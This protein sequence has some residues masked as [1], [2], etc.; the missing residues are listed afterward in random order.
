VLVWTQKLEEKSVAF[1]GD[2]TSIAQS[3]ARQL[4]WLSYHGSDVNMY[5]FHIVIEP[6]YRLYMCE[7]LYQEHSLLNIVLS[8][9]LRELF[10]LELIFLE[11]NL[12][13]KWYITVY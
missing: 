5:L 10:R 1:A 9:L 13:A 2:Q 11:F 6:N 7:W 4:Y 3:V 12:N 8:W